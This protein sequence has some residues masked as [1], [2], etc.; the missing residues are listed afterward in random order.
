MLKQLFEVPLE[1]QMEVRMKVR[2]RVQ[3]V[4]QMRRDERIEV[5][6]SA[7]SCGCTRS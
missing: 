2:M 7:A 1:T 6:Q 4:V 3:M 5:P